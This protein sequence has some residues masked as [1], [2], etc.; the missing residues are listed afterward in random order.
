MSEGSEGTE[1]LPQG[2]NDPSGGEIDLSGI[3]LGV[4]DVSAGIQFS[5]IS[6]TT[7]DVIPPP[8]SNIIVSSDVSLGLA[9]ATHEGGDKWI[10]QKEYIVFSNEIK[11]IK[12]SNMIVLRECKESK[13]LL[14]LKYGD[15]TNII[16]RIQTS[17]IIL[18]TVAGFFNATKVQFGL[19]DPIISVMSISI[20]TYV[21]LVLSVSK[22][23]KYDEIKENIQSLREKYS[24][25]HNQIEHRMDVLGPWYDPNLWKYANAAEKLREWRAVK[26]QMDKEYVEIINSKKE[27]TTQYEITMD[28]K[29]R[30]EYNINN[31]KLTYSN[32]EKMFEWQKKE[33]ILDDKIN[34]TF[35]EYETERDGKGT[36]TIKHDLYSDHEKIQDNWDEYEV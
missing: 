19:Q 22:Y 31:R 2:N 28:T 32:R 3:Q 33:M 15:L 23:F 12:K 5:I 18:S 35:L 34:D 6:P 4:D 11:N 26:E 29:A 8:N 10:E 20:S 36:T 13:R 17:V 21:S 7:G 1:N 24:T 30:N 14:D 9:I 16:N 25:L 27:L